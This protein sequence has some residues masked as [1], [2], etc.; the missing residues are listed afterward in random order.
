MANTSTTRATLDEDAIAQAIITDFTN[1]PRVAFNDADFPNQPGVYG[2]FLTGLQD[3]IRTLFG[4]AGTGV[5]PAYIGS[6]QDSLRS[7]CGR[8]RQ[9]LADLHGLGIENLVVS[10]L[11]FERA[12]AARL[13]EC[14]LL[15][16]LDPL[17]N[18][19]V[20]RAVG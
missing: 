17:L 1:A 14:E 3:P 5:V 4:L 7:R 6:A 12:G 11:P 10:Y 18:A 2:Y 13:A 9:S 8:Y 19:R 16:E 20:C 15:R